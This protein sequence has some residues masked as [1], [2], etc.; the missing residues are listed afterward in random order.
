MT[1][2]G[3]AISA[4]L[5]LVLLVIGT[6]VLVYAIA[7]GMIDGRPTPVAAD[8]LAGITCRNQLV[9]RMSALAPYASWRDVRLSGTRVPGHAEAVWVA[10]RHLSG[11]PRT[12]MLRW[13][14]SNAALHIWI[15]RHWTPQQ[16]TDTA[17]KGGAC[18]D[19]RKAP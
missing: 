14:V 9:T 18:R 15:V 4:M 12:G 5:V 7:L 13:H 17:R 3:K 11:Q 10:R 1:V 6:P 19:D 16:I 2:L 8:G